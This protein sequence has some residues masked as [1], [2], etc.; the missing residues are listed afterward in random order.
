M[1]TISILAA[2]IIAAALAS[3]GALAQSR[4]DQKFIKEAIEGNLAEVQM[5]QLAQKNGASQGV[6][7]FGQMLAADHAQANTRATSV[8]SALKVTPPTEPNAKQKREYNKLS[9]LNGAAFDKA[10]AAGMV[11]DHK[12]DIAAFK[13]AQSSK[14]PN[15]AAFASETLPTLQKH[16]EAAQSLQKGAGKSAA[17]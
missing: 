2:G 10:F 11:T 5:G 3:G 16:L 17:R 6:K 7:D 12:K 8:A 1:R 4:A 14:E 9:K 15:V 13:K